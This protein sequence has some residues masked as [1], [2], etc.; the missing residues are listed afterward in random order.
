MLRGPGLW[1]EAAWLTGVKDQI[2]AL[3][4]WLGP[5]SLWHSIFFNETTQVCRRVGKGRKEMTGTRVSC[6]PAP[7]E[8]TVLL[9]TLPLRPILCPSSGAGILGEPR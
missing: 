5:G 2:F 3:W 6:S 1:E 4:G 8:G 9:C 7:G